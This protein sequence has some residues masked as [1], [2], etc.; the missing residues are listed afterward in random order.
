[1]DME[2]LLRIYIWGGICFVLVMGGLLAVLVGVMAVCF[3]VYSFCPPDIG[4]FNPQVA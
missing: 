2:K 3:I 4:I 1:M